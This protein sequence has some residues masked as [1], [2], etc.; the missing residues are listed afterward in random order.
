MNSMFRVS[1]LSMIMAMLSA[2]LL[3]EETPQ[4]GSFETQFTSRNEMSVVA[5]MKARFDDRRVHDDQDTDYDIRDFMFRVY[6]PEKD[7]RPSKKF[8][9]LVWLSSDARPT[10]SPEHQAVMDE[11]SLIWI[12]PQDALNRPVWHTYGLA[13]DAVHNL[14]KTYRIDPSRL[15]VGG[16]GDGGRLAVRIGIGLSD[17]FN[18]SMASGRVDWFR[19]VDYPSN[20]FARYAASYNPP[21][22]NALGLARQRSSFVFY[23]DA[24]ES[25]DSPYMAT[26]INGFGEMKFRNVHRID[27]A[28]TGVMPTPEEFRLGVAHLQGKTSVPP[29]K[30]ADSN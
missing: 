13:I 21:T 6:V 26:I 5:N 10:F 24:K 22:G 3:G 11:N 25:P 17:V 28:A 12:S 9:V 2:A 30:P 14:R 29:P 4:L 23:T 27:V 7:Y 15:Y 19:R 18:G 8:G 20:A 16:L 1:M